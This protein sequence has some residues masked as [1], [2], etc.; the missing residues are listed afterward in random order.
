MTRL[1]CPR[2]RDVVRELR[3]GGLGEALRAHVAGCGACEEAR[4]VA[5]ALQRDAVRLTRQTAALPDPSNVWVKAQILARWHNAERA[6]RP[7][8][9][10]EWAAIA[11]GVLLFAGGLAW[12]VMQA[13][14]WFDA[15]A[16]SIALA[17]Q[18]AQG[19]ASAMGSLVTASSLLLIV[20][21]LI[22]VYLAWAEQ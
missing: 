14:A 15:A 5:E 1:T 17:R 3:A 12:A 6:A 2:E 10:V 7:I 19:P 11:C 21:I 16:L 20:P 22:G 9:A 8:A 13:G 18:P 4:A